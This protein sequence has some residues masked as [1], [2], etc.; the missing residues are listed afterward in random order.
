MRAFNELTKEYTVV[1][2]DKNFVLN[3]K[4]IKYLNWDEFTQ[5]ACIKLSALFRYKA[6]SFMHDVIM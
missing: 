5:L 1:W 4:L 3:G 6:K 2:V